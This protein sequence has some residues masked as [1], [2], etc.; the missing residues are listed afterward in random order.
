MRNPQFC[1]SGNRPMV[2]KVCSCLSPLASGICFGNR[3]YLVKCENVVFGFLEKGDADSVTTRIPHH[4]PLFQFLDGA[5]YAS[6]LHFL[7]YTLAIE[8]Y[9]S[10]GEGMYF[11]HWVE[12]IQHYDPTSFIFVLCVPLY[13][14]MFDMCI[15]LFRFFVCIH[16]MVQSILPYVF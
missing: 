6:R 9:C 10:V 7:S 15:A 1:V 3:L 8:I 14:S 16:T 5:T 13:I 12:N 2:D 11:L 4:H